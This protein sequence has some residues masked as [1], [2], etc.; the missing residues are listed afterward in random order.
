M[1]QAIIYRGVATEGIRYTY[2]LTLIFPQV[3]HFR[4]LYGDPPL[5]TLI[6]LSMAGT[7]SLGSRR[8]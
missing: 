5:E 1:W 7:G 8:G 6:V 2:L 4:E 3:R